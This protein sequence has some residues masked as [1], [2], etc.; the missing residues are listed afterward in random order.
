MCSVGFVEALTRAGLA[1][2]KKL[3]QGKAEKRR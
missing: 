1:D 2:P 3:D